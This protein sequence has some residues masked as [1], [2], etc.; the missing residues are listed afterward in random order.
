MPAKTKRKAKPSS[1]RKYRGLTRLDPTR[2]VTLRRAFAATLH[3]QFARLKAAILLLIDKEDAFGL[4]ADREAAEQVLNWCNQYGGD[5]CRVG[6]GKIPTRAE[7]NAKVGK[8]MTDGL[9]ASPVPKEQRAAYAKNVS[10]VLNR[11]PDEALSRIAENLQ[12]VN[13]YGDLKELGLSANIEDDRTR[14]RIAS[15]EVQVGGYYRKSDR[16]LA[17]DG[18]SRNSPASALYAHELTHAIDGPGYEISSSPEWGAAFAAE[19]KGGQLTRYGGSKPSEGL[20][21]FGR[22]LYAGDRQEEVRA[23]FPRCWAVFE[24]LGLL[25]RAAPTRQTRNA[26]PTPFPDVFDFPAPM[27]EGGDADVLLK[28]MT[29]NTRWRFSTSPEKLKEFQKWLREQ[30]GSQVAGK[31]QKDL[32]QKFIEEGFRK[33]SGRSFDDV[34]QSRLRSERPELFTPTRQG[35]VGDFYQG[36]RDEF[37]RSSFARPETIEKVQLLAERVYSDLDGITEEMGT[38]MSRTLAEGLTRGQHPNEI[39]RALADEVDIGRGRAE[40]IARTECLPGD[41][42]VDGAVVRTIF[43]RWYVGSMFEI[44]TKNGSKLSA[45][46]NHPVLTIRGWVSASRLQQGDHLIR[47]RRQEN[48][49]ASGNKNV[50]G[51][52]AK[53]GEI[54]ESLRAV[55]VI[56][57]IRG[58]KDDFH[59]DGTDSDVEVLRPNGHLKVGGFSPLY[60]HVV[61]LSLESTRHLPADLLGYCASCSGLLPVDQRVCLVCGAEGHARLNESVSDASPADVKHFGNSGDRSARQVQA[62]DFLHVDVPQLVGNAALIPSSGLGLGIGPNGGACLTNNFDSPFTVVSIPAGDFLGGYPGEVEIDEVV[63]VRIRKFTGH[64]YNLETVQGYYTTQGYYTGN[65][66][67]AHAEGQLDSFKTLGVEEVGVA[68]EWATANDDK[69]CP[70]C[71]SLEGIV[72]KIDEAR[73]LLPRHPNCRCA[74]LPANVGEVSDAQTRTQAGVE[75][76]LEESGIDDVS[77]DSDR[78]ESILNSEQ[79]S[80]AAE[81]QKQAMAVAERQW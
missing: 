76:A 68:V 35:S 53:I 70:K 13:F 75:E 28:E 36:S 52:P 71:Q 79:M 80:L 25:P 37:L 59:G 47:S 12:S 48:L 16:L 19:L 33:G 10:S 8:V 23:R 32:W 50:Q 51:L 14:D 7:S 56:E 43:R 46:A 67:R 73:G 39:A 40:T 66:I 42:L 2:T 6:D 58:S 49:G 31:N 18:D 30:F 3:R 27:T 20:A 60:K 78:P 57:R 38:R 77:V 61:Q 69:V 22:F 64:V 29:M 55:G 5:T 1:K 44:E 4:R 9:K 45:T 74:F 41:A 26:V 17:L 65:C 15:G 34:R 81:F 21:E 24:Q 11:M 54:F 62:D 72:L 63:S